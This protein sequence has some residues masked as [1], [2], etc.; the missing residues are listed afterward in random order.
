MAQYKTEQEATIPLDKFYIKRHRTGW[1]ILSKLHFSLSTGYGGT[2]FFH[3]LDSMG[4][5]QQPDSLPQVFRS[6]NPGS[7][8]IN[9]F[10]KAVPAPFPAAPGSFLVNGDTA[11]IGFRSK[12]FSIPIKATLHVEIFDRYRIGGGYSVEYMHIGR[13]HPINYED[14]IGNFSPDVSNFYMKKYFGMIGGMVYRYYE[15]ALVVDLNVGGYK[16][17]NDFD[18][19]QIK[20]GVYYNL[21]VTA[22]RQFSEYFRLFVRPSYELKN[23][24]LSIPETGLEIKHRANAFYVNVGFTYRLPDVKR[25]PLKDCHAQI[26]HAHGNKEYRSRRHPIWKKQNPHYGENYP[27]L[28]KYKGKNKKKL[29]PY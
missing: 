13:F 11:K 22:E 12:A 23:Y 8:Y 17:G 9:W 14:Q 24:K 20:R 6:A 21:G 7:R 2:T 5:I 15:Y 4:I 18:N 28:I 10:N 27:V 19:S 25:C 29:N 16:L 1:G 3:K 26:I